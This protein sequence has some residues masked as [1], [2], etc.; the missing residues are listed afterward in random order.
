M[1]TMTTMDGIHY[2]Q[3]KTFER[4]IP[5][6]GFVCYKKNK[7]PR[8][9][10]A[11]DKKAGGSFT[12]VEKI[13]FLEPSHGYKDMDQFV[14]VSDE[15]ING[16]IGVGIHITETKKGHSIKY[17]LYYT[18]M[19]PETKY[20]M[21]HGSFKKQTPKANHSKYLGDYPNSLMLE[22]RPT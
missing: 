19:F 3:T 15:I 8:F 5:S 21:D 13:G 17:Y 9:Q 18:D 22:Y 1:T 4:T 10:K 11:Q 16:E 12:K 2:E 14:Q 6:N 7:L 20:G